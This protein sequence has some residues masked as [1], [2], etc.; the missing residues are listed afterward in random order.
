VS[1][2]PAATLDY[3][4]CLEWIRANPAAFTVAPSQAA[5]SRDASVV[6]A[7]TADEIICMVSIH[8]SDRPCAVAAALAVVA[9]AVTADVRVR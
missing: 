8:T 4:T 6:S 2:I 1:P 3:L 5:S 9:D 7:H